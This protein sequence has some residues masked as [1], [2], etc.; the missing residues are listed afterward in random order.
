MEVKSRNYYEMTY[1]Q[2]LLKEKIKKSSWAPLIQVVYGAVNNPLAFLRLVIDFMETYYQCK[3]FRLRLRNLTKKNEIKNKKLIIVSFGTVYST[4]L[5]SILAGSLML[6]GWSVYP[7]IRNQGTYAQRL[8][9][10]CFSIRKLIFGAQIDITMPPKKEIKNIKKNLLLACR[11]LTDLMNFKYRE[12]NIGI[13]LITTLQR[14]GFVASFDPRDKNIQKRIISKVDEIIRWVLVCEKVVEEE[15]PDTI[16]MIEVNDWNRPIVDVAIKNGIDIIQMVQPNEDNGIIFKRI[17]SAT[18]GIH[19]N[20]ISKE[21]L[22]K[23]LIN[24]DWEEKLE[25][26]LIKRYDGSWFLQS[27]NQPSVSKVDQNYINNELCLDEKKKNAIIFSHILWDANLF[28]GKDLFEGYGDWLASTV[29]EAIK[30]TKVNWILKL[31]PANI[32][33]RKFENIRGEYSEISLLKMHSLWPLPE[34][35]TL[36]YPESKISTDSLFLIADYGITVRGTVG[37]EMPCYGIRTFTAGTGR[38]SGLGFTEDFNSKEEY[39]KALGSIEIYPTLEKK[40]ILLAKKHAYLL[41]CKRPWKFS[42]FV[43]VQGRLTAKNPLAYNIRLKT[44][45]FEKNSTITELDDWKK[46]FLDSSKPLEYMQ[47][48]VK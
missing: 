24:S 27:R 22:A 32:W 11:N 14:Q 33:K 2:E 25:Q 5:E 26:H 37:V 15:S 19:P 36:L 6:D 40:S 17:N 10:R 46:W 9:Y 13:T 18:R 41:F 43:V 44:D 8:Y 34:H 23:P 21:T 3:H 45:F 30:N 38:Y 47:D 48:N 12:I 42:S 35:V 20:S 16:L 1:F 4:K 7:F 28:Y 39:L 31:H 29:R